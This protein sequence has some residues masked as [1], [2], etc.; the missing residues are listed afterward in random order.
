MK[1]DFQQAYGGLGFA[2]NELADV[3]VQ[4][5]NEEEVKDEWEVLDKD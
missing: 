1:E 2:D 4:S 3:D 5:V